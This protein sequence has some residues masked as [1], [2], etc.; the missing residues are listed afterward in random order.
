M[1]YLVHMQV[2][3]PASMPAAEADAIKAREKV[4]SQELQNKGAWRHLW[5]VVGEYANFSVF[6]VASHDELHALLSGLPLFPYMRLKVTP[7]AR[8][9]SS[10]HGDKA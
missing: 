3:L 5:R 2:E 7:L 4:Y 10:I 6:D 8:H 9:P 1:L